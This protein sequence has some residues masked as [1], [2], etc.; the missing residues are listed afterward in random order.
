M[1]VFVRY[2]RPKEW[3]ETT[4][5]K[6]NTTKTAQNKNH[7][8]YGTFFSRAV[9]SFAIE[10]VNNFWLAVDITCLQYANRCVIWQ[11]AR[12]TSLFTALISLVVFCSSL[13][14]RWKA[15]FNQTRIPFWIASNESVT[16]A[17]NSCRN[18]DKHTRAAHSCRPVE[19]NAWLNNSRLEMCNDMPQMKLIAR[20]MRKTMCHT[21]NGC[22]WSCA[23]PYQQCL[24]LV[25]LNCVHESILPSGQKQ[26]KHS[27]TT[28]LDA[29]AVYRHPCLAPSLPSAC[30][31]LLWHAIRRQRR[32]RN[33]RRDL[34]IDIFLFFLAHWFSFPAAETKDSRAD[35]LLPN[36]FCCR[37]LLWAVSNNS[38]V[39]EKYHTGS[40]YAHQHH[41]TQK[42]MPY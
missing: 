17:L 37:L 2:R 41:Q 30:F 35:K 42:F 29:I 10:M 34:S 11:N 40:V 12:I 15:I 4:R 24:K 32:E 28:I 3:N 7:I 31:S 26:C 1:F 14:R 39:L 6:E 33:M 5:V 18:K 19:N 13:I 8:F 20:E 36:C 27:S 38:G 9:L 25:F 16:F 21:H 23:S 22:H